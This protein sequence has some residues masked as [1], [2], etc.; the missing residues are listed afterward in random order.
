MRRTPVRTCVTCRKTEGKRA[1]HRFVRTA[2]GIEFD[3]GGKKAGRG[4]Y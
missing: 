3:P 1:L 2:A 4:A